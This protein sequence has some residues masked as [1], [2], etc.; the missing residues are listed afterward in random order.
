MKGHGDDPEL[1]RYLQ[2][3]GRELEAG[4]LSQ[5]TRTDARAQLAV[6]RQPS[7]KGASRACSSVFAPIV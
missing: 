6:A 3:E 4:E 2:I 7:P 5:R 1:A